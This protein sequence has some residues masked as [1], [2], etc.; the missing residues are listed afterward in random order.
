[1]TAIFDAILSG[2][3]KPIAAIL[4]ALGVLWTVRRSG[5]KSAENKNLREAVKSHEVRNEVENRIA[6]ERDARKRLHSDWSE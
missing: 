3:W 5:V 2:M 1:M 4:G 6:V